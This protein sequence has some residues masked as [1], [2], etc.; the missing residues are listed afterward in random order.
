MPDMIDHKYWYRD[1]EF[2]MLLLLVLVSGSPVFNNEEPIKIT[3]PVLFV[4]SAVYFRRLFLN[5][6]FV[7]RLLFIGGAFFVCLLAQYVEFNVFS[8]SMVGIF[9][10]LL[11]GALIVYGADKK[12]VFYYFKVISIFAF[13]SIPFYLTQFVIDVPSLPEMVPTFSPT[14]A[15]RSVFFHT[16]ITTAPNRNAGLF[17]EPGAFQG[18]LNLALFLAPFKKDFIL[19]YKWHFFAICLA[20][21]TTLSTTGY[22]VFFLV[23]FLKVLLLRRSSAW[24]PFLLATIP[25]VAVFS[26]VTFDHLGAKIAD[27]IEWADSAE[28]DFNP[29]RLGSFLFDLH[30]IE[31]RPLTGNG[32]VEETRYADHPY[33]RGENLGH[34]NGFS[35][36]IASM[37]LIGFMSYILCLRKSAFLS[38]RSEYVAF[39]VFVVFLFQ[40]EH[41][42]L[43]PLFL[44]LPFGNCKMSPRGMRQP[45]RR[46]Y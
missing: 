8:L 16:Y 5:P 32:F 30:Y 38:R 15:L 28:V 44:G 17:W 2:Y 9:L 4:V 43:L 42:M 45:V 21:V 36:F 22:I 7:S 12:F 11:V 40:G 26:Y 6:D 18:F 10:R 13:V 39:L 14:D 33:L 31:K 25:V 35:G 1:V 29:S 23:L 41:F 46:S 37:G 34:G 19:R 27:E 3:V 20:I 24:K